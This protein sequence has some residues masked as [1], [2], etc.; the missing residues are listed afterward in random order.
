MDSPSSPELATSTSSPHQQQQDR[1][2]STF[3]KGRLVDLNDTRKRVNVSSRGG[4]WWGG[5]RVNG[6]S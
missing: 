3:S 5:K 6:P 4:P 1:E 2:T